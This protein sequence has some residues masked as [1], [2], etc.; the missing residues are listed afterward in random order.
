MCNGAMDDAGILLENYLATH[1]MDAEV[2]PVM[3]AYVLRSVEVAKFLKNETYKAEG[4]DIENAKAKK[5]TLFLAIEALEEPQRVAF[6]KTYLPEVVS[7]LFLAK[8]ADGEQIYSFLKLFGEMAEEIAIGAFLSCGEAVGGAFLPLFDKE[9]IYEFSM[10]VIDTVCRMDRAL[11]GKIVFA[12]GRVA[13]RMGY[14]EIAKT[15]LENAAPYVESLA[16][17]RFLELCVT[18]GVKNE[19][20]FLSAENFSKQMPEYINLLV[21]IADDEALTRHY[22]ELAEKNLSGKYKKWQP[23]LPKFLCKKT[24]GKQHAVNWKRLI[25]TA[26]SALLLIALVFTSIFVGPNLWYLI[27]A[28]YVEFGEFPQS[29]KAEGVTIDEFTRD[30]RGYFLGSDGAYY[31]KVIATMPEGLSKEYYSDYEEKCTFSDGTK[32]EIGKTYYFK[33]EP[34]RWRILKSKTG[35][36][37]LMSD[38]VL[39]NM[40]FDDNQNTFLESTVE[41]WLNTTF[42][43]QAF[44]ENERGQLELVDYAGTYVGLPT[45]EMI[46]NPRYGFA[47]NPGNTRHIARHRNTTDYARASG[48]YFWTHEE[49]G[50]DYYGMAYWWCMYPVTEGNTNAEVESPNG[51]SA[52]IEVVAPNGYA[53]YAQFVNKTCFG[54][55]PV[56]RMK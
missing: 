55:V 41:R 7:A 16:E 11:Y 32:I 50:G 1:E 48:T 27:R 2:A 5:E 39:C 35:A 30:S 38:L 40:E 20:E 18:L 19:K 53:A 33:V 15:M 36:R 56:I 3:L 22:T 9:E 24:A 37:Y 6:Y 51:Y 13:T 25:L 42:M 43:N 46:T 29:L 34:I 54:V 12:F 31:A 17:C 47:K 4:V 44:S 10:S 52:Y 26:T 23:K 21:A 49:E 45:T 8:N 28:E 14:F